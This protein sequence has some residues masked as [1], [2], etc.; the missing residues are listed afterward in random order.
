MLSPSQSITSGFIAAIVRKISGIGAVG[1]SG[2]VDLR[3]VGVVAGAE[4][5]REVGRIAPPLPEGLRGREFR[6]SPPGRKRGGRAGDEDLVGVAAAGSSPGTTKSAVSSVFSL[7]DRGAVVRASP[8]RPSGQYRSRTSASARSSG[9]TPRPRSGRRSRASAR[10]G[11]GRRGLASRRAL[12]K[13]GG[14]A[15]TRE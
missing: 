12:R 6:S 13:G 14:E 5:D 1:R 8:R 9:S 15:R 7:A 10:S 11:C 2:A 3:L 4:R